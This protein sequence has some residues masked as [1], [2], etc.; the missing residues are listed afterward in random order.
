ATVKAV[1]FRVQIYEREEIREV[2]GEEW[3]AA[4][5][6]ES[7]IKVRSESGSVMGFDAPNGKYFTLRDLA[8]VIERLELVTRGDSEWFGG[9]DVH[10]VYFDGISRESDGV[11]SIFWGS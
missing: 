9:V 7:T 1:K 3:E 5:L 2:S 8:E 6:D 10:H 4:V 11:W